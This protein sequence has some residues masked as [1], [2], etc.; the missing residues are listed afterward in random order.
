MNRINKLICKIFGHTQCKC[1]YCKKY[2]KTK[3]QINFC[4]RCK[5]NLT[6]MKYGYRQYLD[7]IP[8]EVAV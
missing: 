5:L 8:D 6:T 2:R 4:L 3:P 7:K 1:G